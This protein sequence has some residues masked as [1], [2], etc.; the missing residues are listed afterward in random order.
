VTPDERTR[1]EALVQGW[2]SRADAGL[3]S[4]YPGFDFRVCADEL[5]LL[6]AEMYTEPPAPP[7]V[8]VEP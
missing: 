5:D 1:F 4:V 8:D 6:L 2:R 3:V 7:P